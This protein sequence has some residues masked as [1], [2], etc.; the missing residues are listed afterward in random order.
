[1]M[2]TMMTTTLLAAIDPLEEV[3]PHTL[4]RVGGVGITNQMI[5]AAVAAVLMILIF[6]ALFGRVESGPPTGA[7]N[8][9][10]SILE[11]MRVE[12]FRPALK[13][14]TDRFVPFLW[15]LFFFILFC[16]LLGA[17]PWAGS[18]TGNLSVTAA[19]AVVAFGA[20]FFYGV[21]QNGPIGFWT[22]LVPAVDAPGPLKY[23]L[24]GLLFIIEVIGLFI[25]HSVLAVRL[26]ANMMG[27]HTALAAI[28][29]F[30][31]LAID[32]QFNPVL[33]GT[34]LTG[35]LLGQIGVGLLELLVAF[36]QAYVFAFLS[37]IFIAMSLHEH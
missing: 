30:I 5:M 1:M 35:S 11:F 9:F 28:L 24:I 4:F 34:V 31:A 3:L 25:K 29:G 2:T 12:V 8:F 10:E 27:G 15:S 19:L 37:T 18:A 7:R 17:L 22:H 33:Y 13:E 32:N 21:Q 6:P 16:N 36:I 14:H 23:L 26:F 20:T